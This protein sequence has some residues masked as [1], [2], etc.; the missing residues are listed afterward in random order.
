MVYH[1]ENQY[2]LMMVAL[3][4]MVMVLEGREDDKVQTNDMKNSSLY[5]PTIIRVLGR[6]SSN[7]SAHHKPR[8]Y[9]LLGLDRDGLAMMMKMMNADDIVDYDDD[10]DKDRTFSPGPLGHGWAGEGETHG[11]GEEW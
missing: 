1:I 6:Y 11:D 7:P 5:Q 8:T 4:A 2:V 10:D 3:M 9:L